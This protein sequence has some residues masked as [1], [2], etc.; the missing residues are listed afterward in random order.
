[1]CKGGTTISGKAS[2]RL[3]NFEVENSTFPQPAQHE[4]KIK[5]INIKKPLVLGND[6]ERAIMLRSVVCSFR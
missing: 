6:M 3:S 5:R 1:M 4:M 2:Q